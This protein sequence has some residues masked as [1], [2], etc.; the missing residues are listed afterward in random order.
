[1]DFLKCCLN[2]KVLG[3]VAV[4]GIGLFLFAPN[5]LAGGLPVLVALICPLSMLLMMR[6]MGSMGKGAQAAA[7]DGAY[8][9]PMHPAVQNTSPGRCPQCG[10]TLVA[11]AT[12]VEADAV[13]ISRDAQLALLRAQMQVLGEKQGA[14]RERIEQLQAAESS[15]AAPSTALEEAER[16]VQAAVNRK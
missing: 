14:L 12:S 4:V 16:V 11:S 8:A 9:C 10:M 6:G 5:L 2:P 13:P 7:A 15:S 1:M 3:G